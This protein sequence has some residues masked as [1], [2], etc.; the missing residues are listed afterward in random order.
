MTGILAALP[1]HWRHFVKRQL[2]IAITQEGSGEAEVRAAWAKLVA[3]L[4]QLRA[5]RAA[6]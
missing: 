6:E 4:P 2:M 3:G 5:K 1:I